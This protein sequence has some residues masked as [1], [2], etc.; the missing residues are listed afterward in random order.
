[1]KSALS[2]PPAPTIPTQEP[3]AVVND[4]D[5]ASKIYK[6][7]EPVPTA[8]PVASGGDWALGIEKIEQIKASLENLRLKKSANSI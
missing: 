6:T 1:M 3:V 7:V 2:Q 8:P 5:R 4:D